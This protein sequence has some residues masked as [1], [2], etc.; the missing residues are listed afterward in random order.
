V[1][2]LERCF[3]IIVIGKFSIDDKN[4]L[5]FAEGGDYNLGCGVRSRHTVH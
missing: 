3:A 4:P 1:P 2:F 5:P